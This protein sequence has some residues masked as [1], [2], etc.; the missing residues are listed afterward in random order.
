MNLMDEVHV[1]VLMCTYKYSL[2]L[3]RA[4]VSID[5]QTHK[6]IELILVVNC[7]GNIDYKKI[8]TFCSKYKFIKIYRTRI[9][10]LSY[11]LNFGMDKCSSNYILRLDDDDICY[12]N[13]ITKLLKF[14]L[15]HDLD[16]IGSNADY[17]DEGGK[18]IGSS[19]HLEFDNERI[20]RSLMYKNPIIH[21]SVLFNKKSVLSI[22]GYSGG[23]VSEDYDL[24]L[25]LSRNKKIRFMNLEESLI[26]YRIHPQQ[27]KGSCNAYA[28]VCGYLFR[29]ALVRP[30][31]L[32][33]FS[34]FLYIMKSLYCR[35]FR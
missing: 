35:I 20:K 11:N 18:I 19:S 4:I 26:Q 16:V 5:K 24:W 27:S 6:N 15:L 25:R 32:Y 12:S 34:G 28:E 33:F 14:M 7:I 3:E 21:P 2:F 30:N 10:Q 31:P 8:Y 9:C 17:I 1:S 13:R 29:E 23:F 22:G